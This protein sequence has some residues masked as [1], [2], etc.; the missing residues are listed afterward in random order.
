MSKPLEKITCT[1]NIFDSGREY[2]G[3][4]RGYVLDNIK[5]AINS[6]FTQE[7]IKLREAVGYVGHGLREMAG[8]LNLGEVDS[9]NLG[10]GQRAMVKAL[11]ACVTTGLEVDDQGNITHT[12]EVLDNDEGRAL[13]GLHR[14]KVGGFS[15]AAGGAKAGLNT[16]I[17]KIYGFDYVVNPNFAANRGY[18][19]DSAEGDDITEQAVLDSMI[20]AGV[21][22]DQAAER[23]NSWYASA[24]MESASHQSRAA[25]LEAQVTE[26]TLKNQELEK[27]LSEA[28]QI[29]TDSANDA[30]GQRE[31]LLRDFAR[32]YP[33]HIDPDKLVSLATATSTDDLVGLRQILD[34]VSRVNVSTLPLGDT[35]Q[36]FV[37]DTVWA[38]ERAYKKSRKG[39]TP[40]YGSIESAP[41]LGLY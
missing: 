14:S 31:Q 28:Q 20:S 9:I 29:I 23:L 17:D 24:V 12:Q 6:P 26:L 33:V 11:P 27:Q 19:L 32:D 10:N 30:A 25:D 5:K 7:R 13:L 1:F 21:D 2:S 15:W 3:I 40:A 41:D 18:V 22:K 35:G 38:K 39:E 37:Q 34:S 16:L 36:Q 4:K 8:K